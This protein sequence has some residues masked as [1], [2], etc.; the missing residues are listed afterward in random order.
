MRFLVERL[1]KAA[2]PRIHLEAAP[3]VQKAPRSFFTCNIAGSRLVTRVLKIESNL[4][5]EVGR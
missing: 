5:I 3:Q 4:G 1:S 2:G